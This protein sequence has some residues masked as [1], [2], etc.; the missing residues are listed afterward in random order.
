MSV[1]IAYSVIGR[2]SEMKEFFDLLDTNDTVFWAV[3]LVFLLCVIAAEIL[4]RKRKE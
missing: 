2:K 1:G 4:N 3:I